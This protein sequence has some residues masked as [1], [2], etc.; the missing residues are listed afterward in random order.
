MKSHTHHLTPS[1]TIETVSLEKDNRGK[2]LYIY[3]H[4]GNSFRLFEDGVWLENFLEGGAEVCLHF[5]N[6]E[7]QDDYLMEYP[8][9]V[10]S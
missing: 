6:E 5:D 1:R 7:E 3:N 10:R 2:T 9:G 8:S 4:E